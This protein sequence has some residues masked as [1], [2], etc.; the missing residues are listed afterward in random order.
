MTENTT[1]QQAKAYLKNTREI[2]IENLNAF[3]E[4]FVLT[5]FDL[6]ESQFLLPFIYFDI[7]DGT[8]IVKRMPYNNEL[9]FLESRKLEFLDFILKYDNT[10]TLTEVFVDVRR[11]SESTNVISGA[12][13]YSCTNK[14]FNKESMSYFKYMKDV[15]N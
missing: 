12:I 13:H 15:L 11:A 9:K 10:H 3:S 7:V 2:F 5:V 14:A 8:R 1:E 4:K 6:I